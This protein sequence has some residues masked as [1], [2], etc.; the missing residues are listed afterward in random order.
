MTEST[1]RRFP[2]WVK[3]KLLVL[4]SGCSLTLVVLSSLL[5]LVCGKY[6][7]CVKKSYTNQ[8]LDLTACYLVIEITTEAIALPGLSLGQPEF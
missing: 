5:L 1:L 7:L 8:P 2:Q 6:R 4:V 3:S